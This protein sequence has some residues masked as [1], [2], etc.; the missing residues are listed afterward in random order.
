[1]RSALI[2]P[3]IIPL[4]LQLVNPVG[5]F[6]NITFRGKLLLVTGGVL[7]GLGRD[8]FQNS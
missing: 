3:V 8:R 7:D 2:V 1:M 4:K 5:L 6:T